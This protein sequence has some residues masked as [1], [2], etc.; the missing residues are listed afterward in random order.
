MFGQ[1]IP[2]TFTKA[3]KGGKPGKLELA[4]IGIISID[5]AVT[6]SVPTG[7]FLRLSGKAGQ[8]KS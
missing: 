6:S 3:S 2:Y 4:D 8:T 7:K 1:A 5:K